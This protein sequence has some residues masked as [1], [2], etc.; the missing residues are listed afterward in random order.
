MNIDSQTQFV[1]YNMV[2]AWDC[3]K[4]LTRWI[5]FRDGTNDGFCRLTKN[6]KILCP[7]CSEIDLKIEKAAIMTSERWTN[8]S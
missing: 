1:L 5:H 6:P 8:D 4:C 3:D 2:Q 7:Q